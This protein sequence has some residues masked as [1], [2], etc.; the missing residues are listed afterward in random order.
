MY[1]LVVLGRAC[2]C[3][4]LYCINHRMLMRSVDK[5]RAS[6]FWGLLNFLIVI[7]VKAVLFLAIIVWAWFQSCFGFL[8]SFVF[9]CCISRI[10]FYL[11][12][13]GPASSELVINVHMWC[14]FRVWHV[15]RRCQLQTIC[16]LVWP[17]VVWSLVEQQVNS[18]CL[19]C[20]RLWFWVMYTSLTVI[21]RF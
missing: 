17:F 12:W 20:N 18:L 9:H 8:F 6:A 7:L 11:S 2:C 4:V 13:C 21:G 19:C 3:I 1:R 5:E 16:D 14:F 10:L 15:K